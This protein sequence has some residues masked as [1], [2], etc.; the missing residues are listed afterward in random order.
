MAKKRLVVLISGGGSNLQALI[1]ATQSG[2]LDAEIVLVVSNRKAAYGLQ[3]AASAGIST[4][5]C[6][7]KAYKD[8]HR[9]RDEYDADL[10]EIVK[11]AAPELVVLAGWMHILSPAFLDRVE[12]RVVNLHPALPGQFPGTHAIQRAFEAYQRGEITTTG[13]MIHEV[14]PEVDAGP[15]IAQAVVPILQGDTLATLEQ[16][17][18]EAEHRLIVEAVGIALGQA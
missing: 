3:R 12:A 11:E 13:C 18:H 8:A 4:A 6:S 17:M 16:R 1:D 15:V 5:Y 9:S 2:D 7:L 10:A 14:V